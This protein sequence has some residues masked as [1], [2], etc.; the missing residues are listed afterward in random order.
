MAEVGQVIQ[1]S[2]NDT[3]C[4]RVQ[5]LRHFEEPF[6]PIQCNKTCDNCANPE[7]IA[8]EDMTPYAVSFIN[9]LRDAKQGGH[10][11]TRKQAIDAFKGKAKEPHLT[12]SALFGAGE[13]IAL[14]R[15]ERLYDH[16]VSI[17]VFAQ[18]LETNQGNYSNQYSH[19]SFVTAGMNFL[20][21]S[22]TGAL[23]ARRSLGS[24]RELGTEIEHEVPCHCHTCQ[25]RS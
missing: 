19:V 18:V 8:E 22:L 17:R 15:L 9:L 7:G 1:F 12:R 13:K 14:T 25:T 20:R 21:C 16:L 3:D 6:D 5:I 11:V 23:T 2:L 24:I 10:K 4:R